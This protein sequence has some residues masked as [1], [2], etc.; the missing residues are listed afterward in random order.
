MPAKKKAKKA[1]K[2][3]P[4]K[5]ASNRSV[6][7]RRSASNCRQPNPANDLYGAMMPMVGMGIG[8]GML[9]AMSDSF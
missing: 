8:L 5:S 6:S 7:N 1:G 4:R 2:S 9:G 3:R